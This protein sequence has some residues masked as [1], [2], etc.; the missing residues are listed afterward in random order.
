M[1]LFVIGTVATAFNPFLI[2]KLFCKLADFSL[3]F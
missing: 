2:G 1:K 3:Q